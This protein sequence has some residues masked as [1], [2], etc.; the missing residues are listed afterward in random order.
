MELL[1]YEN[2]IG[3][4]GLAALVAPGEGV[5]PKLET[6]SLSNTL[7]TDV[8]CAKLVAA[9]D[10][11]MLPSLTFLAVGGPSGAAVHAALDRAKAR[12]SS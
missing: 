10:S 6:L 11:G 9:F 12:R 4:E 2:E 8:G 1:V 7:F 5:L 3:D